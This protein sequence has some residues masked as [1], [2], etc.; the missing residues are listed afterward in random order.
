[1]GILI[2]S[3]HLKRYRDMAKLLVK[4][5]FYDAVRKIGL[6]EILEKSEGDVSRTTL[7]GEELANDLEEMGPTFVKLGQFLSTR[8]DVLPSRRR[9]GLL[10]SCYQE[11]GLR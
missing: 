2:K 11:S 5:G 4:Y 7:E 10:F 1:M 6:D 8:P 9:G 3:E